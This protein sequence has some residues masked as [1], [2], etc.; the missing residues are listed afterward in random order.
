LAHPELLI[1]DVDTSAMHAR[2]SPNATNQGPLT[3]RFSKK[4]QEQVNSFLTNCKFY[5][6]ENV[7]LPKYSS[8]VV[9]RNIFEE[10]KETRL[11]NG[12]IRK[13][14][15]MNVRMSES[16][17]M[18]VWTS[19]GDLRISERGSHNSQLLEALEAHEDILESSSSPLSHASVPT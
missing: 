12:N 8:L 5:T 16:D 3:R 4:L 9:H 2:S 10:E 14:T 19:E 11:Q 18:N 1:T 13:I 17:R 6:S 7:I 15:H